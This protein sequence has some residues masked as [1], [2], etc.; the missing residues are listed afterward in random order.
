MAVN[1]NGRPHSPV[2]QQARHQGT[3]L[4]CIAN[5]RT[6]AL[7]A[8]SWYHSIHDRHG[9]HLIN[10]KQPRLDCTVQSI[11]PRKYGICCAGLML[12]GV[13]HSILHDA[14]Q[15]ATEKPGYQRQ[16]AKQDKC[17]TEAESMQ[18]ERVKQKPC[19]PAW[20]PSASARPNGDTSAGARSDGLVAES[21]C[22]LSASSLPRGSLV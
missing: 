17:S 14:H 9:R 7:P 4:V 1:A 6:R 10:Q 21:H 13:Q 15:Q 5:T 3:L 12:D 20:T 16:T 2:G 8:Q 22:R 19:Q 11:E 18:T